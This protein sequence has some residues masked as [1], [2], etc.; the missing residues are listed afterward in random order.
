MDVKNLAPSLK[1][2][3]NLKSIRDGAGFSINNL[4]TEFKNLYVLTAD[5]RE[6]VRVEEFAKKFPQRF[7]ECGVA[8]QN[9]A[10]IAAGLA[11]C[12]NKSIITSFAVFSP[13]RNWDQ[14]RVSI[15][16]SKADVKILGG[17]AGLLT[18]EDGATH[19]ALEDIAIMRTLPDMIVINPCD[20]NQAIK[21]LDFAVEYKGPVYIRSYRE[22]TLQITTS[23]TLLEIGE[24]QIFKEGNDLTLISSGPIISEVLKTVSKLEEKYN[25]SVELINLPFIKPLNPEK[26]LQSLRKTKKG[27]VIEEHQIS[28]GVGSAVL[29]KISESGNFPLKLIGINSTF[30]ESGKSRDLYEKYEIS[31]EFQIKKILNFLDRIK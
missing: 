23:E 3:L 28:G 2:D 24:P 26:I 20:Y 27:V 9:M 18:G 8:E 14:I 31:S 10:G 12:G 7:I 11:L 30:G 4:G 19:Q 1:I 5:L 29:E 13:G 17:H 16:Y 25:L 15:C 6:S 22:K 21:A